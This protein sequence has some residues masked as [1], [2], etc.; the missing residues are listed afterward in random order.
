MSPGLTHAQPRKRGEDATTFL[1][2]FRLSS[3]PAQILGHKDGGCGRTGTKLRA[4]AIAAKRRKT[5][6]NG[7]TLLCLFAASAALHI[8]LRRYAV[9]RSSHSLEFLCLFAASAWVVER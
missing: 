7:E 6:K 9:G 4:G 8:S 3:F 5:R 1:R 2:N